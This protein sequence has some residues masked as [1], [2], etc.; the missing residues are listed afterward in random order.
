MEKQDS[1]CKPCVF[2]CN[3]ILKNHISVKQLW[4]VPWHKYKTTRETIF[5]DISQSLEMSKKEHTERNT[6]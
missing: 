1:Y 4:R 2:I 3:S 5:T 6:S